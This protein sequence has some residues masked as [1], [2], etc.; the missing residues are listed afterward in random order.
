M[1]PLYF[2]KTFSKAREVMRERGWGRESEGGEE[3]SYASL[4]YFCVFARVR[5]PSSP[6]AVSILIFEI[7][8]RVGC[9]SKDLC[10]PH[11]HKLKLF[12]PSCLPTATNGVHS[13]LGTLTDHAHT[14]KNKKSWKPVS[15]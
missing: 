11:T 13:E 2:R 12:T 8:G 6:A 3:P 4:I 15:L 10:L 1:S 5:L 14:L 7:L 9:R